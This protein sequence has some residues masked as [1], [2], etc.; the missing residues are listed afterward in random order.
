VSGRRL[1]AVGRGRGLPANLAELVEQAV[2]ELAPSL[3][4]REPRTPKKFL[5]LEDCA[6]AGESLEAMD[7]GALARAWRTL[8]NGRVL[9][10]FRD[11]IERRSRDSGIPREEEARLRAL[12]G[13]PDRAWAMV[14][15]RAEAQL[16]EVEADPE[17]ML[18]AGE[19]QLARGELEESKAYLERAIKEAPDLVDAHD[20]LG[21]VRQ[22]EADLEGARESFERAVELEPSAERLSRVAEVL[23]AEARGPLLLK[24][25]QLAS[26]SLRDQTAMAQLA[27]VREVGPSLLADALEVEGK[28]HARMLE[29]D[30]ASSSVDLAIEAGG[31]TPERLQLRGRSALG[32]G[33]SLGAQLAYK[34]VL[35]LEPNNVEALRAVGALEVEAGETATGLARLEQAAELEPAN[36]ETV[37]EL[38]RAKHAMGDSAAALELYSRADRLAEPE[39]EDLL[40]RAAIEKELGNSAGEIATLK[41][42]AQLEPGD[43]A[44]YL[45][46]SEAHRGAGNE[47]EAKKYDSFV[48][49]FGGA[50][51]QQILR[52]EDD[53]RPR[54]EVSPS[55]DA[56]VESLLTAN[57]PGPQRIMVLDPREKLT[58]DQ[59][60]LDWVVPRVPDYAR[61]RKALEVAFANRGLEVVP[62]VQATG[63][64][65]SQLD[66]LFDFEADRS[67]D[68]EAAA[69][70]N[71]GY[72]TDA[73]LLARLERRPAAD[74]QAPVGCGAEAYYTIHARF[75][76]GKT[77]D[78]VRILANAA[79]LPSG[80]TAYG[81]WNPRA[82]GV[83]LA[84]LILILFPFVRGW[85]RITVRFQLP[86]KTRALFSVRLSRRRLKIRE[87]DAPT[88]DAKWKI[89][90]KLQAMKGNEKRLTEGNNKLEFS[91]VAARRRP[92][93]ITVR[94]PIVDPKTEQ[95]VGSFNAEK[96]VKVVRGKNIHVE[97]DMRPKQA[98]IEVAVTTGGA[99]AEKARVGVR[100]DAK[101]VR[102]TRGR[103]AFFYLDPGDYVLVAAVGG[104]VVEH[105]VQVPDKEPM[106][107]H[108]DVYD[109]N[110]QVFGDCVEAVTPYLEGHFEGAA[111]ALE[112]IDMRKRAAQVRALLKIAPEDAT[113]VREL[114]VRQAAREEDV[115]S[116]EV[117]SAESPESAELLA[118][119]GRHEEAA[120]QFLARGCVREAAEA[121]ENAYAWDRAAECYRKVGDDAKLLEVLERAAESYEAAVVATRVGDR[122]RALS[123]LKRVDKRHQSY[124]EACLMMA[125]Q[126]ASRGDPD[127][128]IEKLAEAHALV[129]S[130]GIPIASQE[131]YAKLLEDA[132]RLDEAI[133]VYRA[134]RRIDHDHTLAKER[135]EELKARQTAL[136]TQAAT[137]M[138]S[139]APT[140]MQVG[141]AASGAQESRYEVISELGRGAMGIVYKARDTVLG[142]MVAL[143]RLPDSMQEHELAIT[144]FLRE[145][146]SAA[147]L[148]HPN[149]VT[150][151]DA[152]QEGTAYFITMECLEGTPVDAIL[153]KVG[154]LSPRDSA[155]LGMQAANG[156][157][158][159][160]SQRIIHRDIKASNLFYTKDRV[161]KIMDFGLAKAVEEVRKQASVIAGTP[162]YMP[163]EQAIGGIVDHRSDLY[164]LGVTIYQLVTGSVPFPD[165]DVIYHHAHTPAPDARE[166]VP[167]VPESLATL[168]LQLMAKDPEDRV[169]SAEEV[170]SRLRD[171]VAEI[172]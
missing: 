108:I 111:R 43:P 38:A 164:S 76:G 18:A 30:R 40:A 135:I 125:E 95:L 33:N 121:F 136:A 118:E 158:Y 114:L 130:D 39:V 78:E 109:E 57:G 151:Y 107:V 146:R 99:M 152:G 132:E 149:I 56:L 141:G 67:R 12:T 62:T 45:S 127:L 20:A 29:F 145:A 101:S 170:A 168:L 157:Q 58:V 81:R 3:G 143:K 79:C 50:H 129:S 119:A 128:A 21:R 10:P 16:L 55:I 14:F 169:Q 154:K 11:A 42:A 34:S 69:R 105:V 28:L 13:E 85:G 48:L 139:G 100:G 60:R 36:P 93:V 140:P 147:A 9:E 148:N 120:T 133:E 22:S 87:D 102:F 2:A 163:P 116:L 96:Q 25:A 72:Q 161:V 80:P 52:P 103:P 153:K 137:M 27:T 134:I 46:L 150:V 7:A 167:E 82:A 113:P 73:L 106:S 4:I 17:V 35:A 171:V 66:A 77:T 26:D 166:R 47:E 51:H 123:N 104:A 110:A 63:Y 172:G 117:E 53:D 138:G 91:W 122:D 84:A 15:A 41:R 144:Y 71:A 75:L 83:A 74:P 61:I 162:Y 115:V 124:V 70:L 86:P 97:F 68:P 88:D 54:E 159:A 160:H 90:E 32:Q 59:E 31:E 131:L 8:P 92:Y 49:A 23:P 65:A 64:Y 94:G 155:I 156:L 37:R 112:A 98:A 19:I 142:R 44:I 5:S 165:G 1:L 126:L 6:A 89:R 24:S